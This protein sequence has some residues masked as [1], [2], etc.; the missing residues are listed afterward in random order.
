M[1]IKTF[2][3]ILFSIYLLIH[4]FFACNNDKKNSDS[5][6]ISNPVKQPKPEQDI[7]P[8]KIG[9]K[10]PGFRLPGVDGKWHTLEEFEEAKALVVVFLANHCPTSQGFE[11][12]IIQV[13]ED[14]KP[15][16]VAFVAISGTSPFGIRDDEL[17]YTDV[18]DSFDEMV[19]RAKD[20]G[21]KFPYLY[22]GDDQKVTMAYGP[23]ATPHVFVFDEKKVHRYN[24]RIGKKQWKLGQSED[25][26]H[27]LEAVLNGTEI[28][29][30]VT[31]AF[32]CNTKWS[33]LYEKNKKMKQRW[34]DIPIEIEE[35]TI[36]Q[37]QKLLKNDQS[38]KLRLINVWATWCGPCVTEYPEL[39]AIY[40]SFFQR[41]F[42]F[43]SLCADK[44]QNKN[45]ALK[46]LRKQKSHIKNYIFAGD[47]V[48]DLVEA[49]DPEW[50]AALPYT[51]MVEPGGKVVYRHQGLID[52]IDLRR[53]IVDHPLLGRD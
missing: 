6:F 26:R 37:V 30:P 28:E 18:A 45:S 40:R 20:K 21:F 3:E 43:I 4:L 23:T 2:L 15:K 10:A 51:I 8:L 1:K 49:V 24:G 9:L 52:P 44:I 48:Y 27:A 36:A 7:K 47:D 39:M 31:K 42:E 46:F 41:D 14:Y 32:G 11:D 38:E 16:D 19:I 5:F 12:Q 50:N 53:I 22:D 17:G 33:W 25:L 29:T 34:M 35:V 13:Y